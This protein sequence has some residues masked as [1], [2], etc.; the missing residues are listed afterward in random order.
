MRPDIWEIVDYAQA[1]GAMPVIGTNATLIT[2][3]IA[4]KMAEHKIPRISVSID[5][6]TAEEHDKF[7]G[8]PGAS[9]R[10]SRASRWPSAT[11][12]ACRST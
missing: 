3:E 12:W 9:T 5:F 8:Q 1:K 7:R 11:A 10:R 4:A 6:P 2:D